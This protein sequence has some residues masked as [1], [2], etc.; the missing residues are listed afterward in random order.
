MAVTVLDEMKVLDQQ[1]AP[2]RPVAKQR[3]DVGNRRRIDL[4][5]L[6][7][8]RGAALAAGSIAGGRLHWRIHLKTLGF[9]S[10]E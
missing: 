5:A 3:V 2:A 9:S 7:R 4:A 10:F 8:L 6:R 1:V